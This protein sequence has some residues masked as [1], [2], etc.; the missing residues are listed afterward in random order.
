MKKY[1]LIG[2]NYEVQERMEGDMFEHPTGTDTISVYVK[3]ENENVFQ[4]TASH[5][6]G[7]CGSGYCGASWGSL[8]LG[9]VP[10][11]EENGMNVPITHVVEGTHQVT[12]VGDVVQKSFEDTDYEFDACV[13]LVKTTD[14][15]M[16]VASS[17]NGGCGYY[18]SGSA[19][20]NDKLFKELD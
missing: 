7:S 17:G 8:S 14:G 20:F 9:L 1:T 13:E 16:V 11:I 15:T 4:F 19:W 6:D 2:L 18:P 5:S 10:I 12:I 3:D